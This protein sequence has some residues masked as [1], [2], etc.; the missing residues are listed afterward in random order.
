MHRLMT[1][2]AGAL[3]AVLLSM[4]TAYCQAAPADALTAARELVVASRATDQFKALL[5]LI[6]QQLKPVVVQGRPEIERDYDKIMPLMMESAQRQ[7]DQMMEEMAAIYA[8]NFTAD[9]IRQ[10]TAFYRTPVGQKVLDKTPI[11]A[12]QSMMSGQKF[13]QRAAQELQVRIREELRKRGH[14]I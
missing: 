12:Q 11:I 2:A 4:G 7:L 10:V 14:N 1:G 13:G 5:P 3:V 8:G 9:E 6:I